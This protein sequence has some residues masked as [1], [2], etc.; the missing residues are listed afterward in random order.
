MLET[1][2]LYYVVYQEHD[3][4][5]LHVKQLSGDHG[6]ENEEEELKRLSDLELDSEQLIRMDRLGTQENIKSIGDYSIKGGY[7]DVDVIW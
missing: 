7:K 2:E 4:P 5:A 6:V 3:Q 1:P